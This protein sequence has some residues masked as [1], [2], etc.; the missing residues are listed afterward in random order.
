MCSNGMKIPSMA[1][2]P[3][4]RCL[5][6]E[7]CTKDENWAQYQELSAL[8]FGAKNMTDQ[9]MHAYHDK[10]KNTYNGDRK[11]VW[12]HQRAMLCGDAWRTVLS[13]R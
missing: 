6:R 10:L 9:H 13:M 8:I 4:W 11:Q 2:K 3:R 7:I 12:K 1:L 5:K